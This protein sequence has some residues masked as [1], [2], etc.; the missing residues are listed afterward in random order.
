MRIV[1][2]LNGT[3]E[4]PFHR[5]GLR[6]NPFPQL[7]IAEYDKACLVVQS[8]GGD[9]IPN[10]DYIRERLEGF[11]PEFIE[12]CCRE[13]RKGETVRF[14]VYWDEEGTCPRDEGFNAAWRDDNGEYP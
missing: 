2:V 14:S 1:V 7:G 4:N 10:T 9:P 12:L 5:W 6:Q 13:F 11:D 3:D 8:L